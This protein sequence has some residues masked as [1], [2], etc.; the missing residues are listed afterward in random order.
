M[1]FE[2]SLV[3]TFDSGIGEG[4]SEVVSFDGGIF[5][6]TNGE[7]DRIDLFDGAGGDLIRAVFFADAL[8]DDAP[9][10]STT[11]PVANYDGIQSVAIRDGVVAV[12][13]SR[14]GEDG[15]VQTFSAD[16]GA[17]IETYVVGNLPDQI[18]FSKDGTRLFVANEGERGEE[19]D[20]ANDPAPG[21]ISII[22]LTTDAQTAVSTFGFTQFD[23]FDN[24]GAFDAADL[25]ALRAE[26]IRTFPNSA[27][28]QDFE[29]EYIVEGDDGRLYVAIQENNA[30]AVFDP[31]TETFVD[32]FSA[33]IKDYSLPGNAFD[34]S[35]RDGAIAIQ[36]YDVK[37]WNQPDGIAT[38][39]IGGET[40]VF[41]AN[42]G[43]SRDFDE[44]RVADLNLDPAAYPN[45][46]A[47]QADEVLGRLQADNLSGDAD[48]DGDI[49]QIWA[50]GG[51]SFTILDS[52]GDV[53]FDSGDDFEQITAAARVPNAFN[54]DDFVPGAG[55]PAVVDD[56]RSDA[57]GPEP[58]AIAVGQVGDRV[59]AFIGMERDSGI[60]V[61]DVT[62]PSLSLFVDYIDARADGNISP[63]VIQF[64]PA[65]DSGTG[66]A[67]IAVSFEV[68]GTTAVYDILAE[69]V[70]PIVDPVE[71]GV[72]LQLLHFGDPEFS[73]LSVETAPYIGALIDEFA[74]DFSNTLIL[75]SGDNIIPGPFRTAS[76]IVREGFTEIQ[77]LNALGVQATAIGNHEFDLGSGLF[78][79]AVEASNFPHIS[80]NLDFSGDGS[81]A[82][83]FV[84]T[85][86]G[87]GLESAS[88]LAGRIAP[89][90]VIEQNGAIFGIV[91]ATTQILETITSNGGVEVIGPNED[92]MPAL[93]AILQPVIDDL[94]AQGVNKIIL[95]S[96]LQ[97]I[98]LEQALAPL[99][100]G[101]DIIIAGG[102][103]TRLG[104]DNDEA[105]AFPGHA[106]T[107]QGDY[108]IETTDASGNPTLIVNTDNELTYLGRLIVDFDANGNVITD[109][110]AQNADIAGAYAAA[111]ETLAELRGVGGNAARVVLSEGQNVGLG[112]GKFNVF[113]KV[114]GGEEITVFAGGVLELDPSFN[115]GG[116]R[117][118]FDG[119]SDDFSVSLSGSVM[120]IR[121]GDGTV[122]SLPIGMAGTVLQFDDQTLVARFD[123][124]N[125]RLGD[126]LVS[127][128][129]TFIGGAE[130]GRD[131]SLPAGLPDSIFADGTRAG[132]VL[133]LVTP[134]GDTISEL[135]D[136]VFGFTSVYL[137]GARS[138]VRTEETNL[139]NLTADAN[140]YV[141]E[142]RDGDD[143]SFVVS[144]KN[145]GGIRAPI[146]TFSSPGPNGEVTAL[147]PQPDGAVSQLDVGAT[148]RFDNSLVAVETDAAGLKA[149]LERGVSGTP[150]ATEG[151]FPQ[152][153]GV[154]FSFDQ[155]EEVGERVNDIALVAEDG[156][157]VPLF[158]DGVLVAGADALDIT[159]VTLGF[160]A[161]GGDGYPFQDIAE[162]VSAITDDGLVALTYDENGDLVGVP[163]TIL[164]EQAALAEYLGDLFGTVDTAF[165][166]ADTPIEDD[167]RIQNEAFRDSTVLTG[168]ATGTIPA[169]FEPLA[170]VETAPLI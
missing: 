78:A 25:A 56:N 5:A 161:E 130:T 65:T 36:N 99:L 103:N 154:R 22:D 92:D 32:I 107:F 71:D 48:G 77:V 76:G 46:A 50:F 33:G 113:G 85:T 163:D 72:T 86:A 167:T 81:T 129:D 27:P 79:D 74:P 110:I 54:N 58:E 14:D 155:S 19:P 10:D 9:A 57:K 88:S 122:V 8:P 21:S 73:R 165:A 47:L 127:D 12:A 137:E 28:S 106:A 108:P 52:D 114:A 128:T 168:E 124:T 117:L 35:D 62:E 17:A 55:D 6:V 70:A 83:L 67:Q 162:S 64:I 109:S 69:G 96:H 133:D 29:P 148:L 80:A 121:G 53:V 142:Q 134:I 126:Q 1:G 101:V 43:D 16:T 66:N 102:S 166:E 141:Y 3:Q 131:T 60:F 145:G 24:S 91:G 112:A 149:I 23:D 123:G 116:D 160:I 100:D 157:L 97:Q 63:E 125:V 45:A 75:S 41:T 93:A 170:F 159:I 84:D 152:V 139:G 111:P 140:A 144:V 150:G 98:Q 136:N 15:I 132:A 158:D 61:Y 104:D 169:A 2:F 20:P 87:A 11:I 135:G 90:A 138:A 44:T 40:Y 153:G 156:S 7:Q 31:A 49:D 164:G 18:S 26:G 82:D 59:L 39:T 94:T 51:R 13:I 147:P 42:E 119:S 30:I 143:D 37:G 105:V 4:G 120:I 95:V 89:S 118:V 151:R 38:F 115:N 34:P 68:S 146:G